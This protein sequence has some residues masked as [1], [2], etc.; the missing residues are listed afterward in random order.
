MISFAFTN[1]GN[2]AVT[3][4]E[5]QSECGC[6][7]A[8]ADKTTVHP[9]ES[10]TVDVTF[11]LTGR[12]GPQEKG[13]SVITDEPNP[14][15]V[16]LL[17]STTIPVA[18]T[19]SPERLG[20]KKGEDLNPKSISLTN[21]TSSPIRIEEAVTTAADVTVELQT[22]R[23]GYEY[24]VV[25]TPVPGVEKAI[26]PIIIRPEKPAELDAVRTYRVYAIIGLDFPLFR[27][28]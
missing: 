20:W 15:P 21:M 26:A 9:G 24:S 1:T 13:L 6:I 7:S 25:V 19:V 4:H 18:F 23:E 3:I 2:Y 17:V 10:G 22:V 11:M 12:T 16:R 28:D 14:H 27:R 8:Q 5:V